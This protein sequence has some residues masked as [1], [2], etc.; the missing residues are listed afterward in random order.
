MTVSQSTKD[1]L[2]EWGIPKEQIAIVLNGATL[3]PTTRNKTKVPT[4]M[5]LGA[6]SKDKGIEDALRVFSTIAQKHPSWQYWVV[7]KGDKKYVQYLESKAAEYGISEKVTFY[8]YVDQ[9]KKFD[10]LS[11]GHVLINPSVR[12]GWGLVNIEAASAGT[13][14]VAYDVAGCR[15]SVRHNETGLLVGIGNIQSLADATISIIEDKKA[16]KKM[17]LAG[18]EWSKKFTWEQSGKESLMFIDSII[19]PN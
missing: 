10:L 11:K 8:G 6:L 4:V 16:F 14:V 12:E 18:V 1:D 19:S 3:L 2:H 9:S 5:Y 7:G 15:D 13:V 17:S